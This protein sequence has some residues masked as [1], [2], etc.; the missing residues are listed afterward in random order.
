MIS[1]LHALQAVEK[2][3]TAVLVLHGAP[4]GRTPALAGPGDRAGEAVS[5][6]RFAIDR[7]IHLNLNAVAFPCGEPAVELLEPEE[8]D[9]VVASVMDSADARIRG[10]ADRESGSG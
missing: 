3:I 8:V 2:A 4:F 10:M 7:R 5:D 6:L 9:E 1:L